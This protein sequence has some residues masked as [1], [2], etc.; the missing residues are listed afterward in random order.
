[1]RILSFAGA[2]HHLPEGSLIAERGVEGGAGFG[3]GAGYVEEASDD[4]TAL[5][6]ALGDQRSPGTAQ[7][8][9]SLQAIECFGE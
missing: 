4:H 8:I 9:T 7:R 5:A 6:R 3:N 2:L 1:M